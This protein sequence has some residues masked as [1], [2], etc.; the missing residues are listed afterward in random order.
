MIHQTWARPL[1]GTLFSTDGFLPQGYCIA[2][3][4]DLLWTM[5]S[6]DLL[7]GLSYWCI[8]LSLLYFRRQRRKRRELRIAG[9]DGLVVMFCLFIFGCGTIHLLDVLNVWRPAYWAQAGI[10][11]L[12]AAM[13]VGTAVALWR[14][15][16]VAIRFIHERERN[17]REL[18]SGNLRL[19]ESLEL[20]E[21]QREGLER[22][23]R[24]SQLMQSCRDAGELA[25]LVTHTAREWSGAP[26]GALFMAEQPG[27]R[28]E[29]ASG[30][31]DLSTPNPPIDGLACW[32]LRQGRMHPDATSQ[33]TPPCR[34]FA[35][36]DTR[37][38]CFPLVAENQN[39][40]VL[41][42]RGVQSIEDPQLRTL[43]TAFVA[44]AA[45]SLA[46]IQLRERLLAQSIRDPLT[47]MFNRR[48]LEE[49]L[50]LEETRARRNGGSFAVIM[51]DLDHFK[52]LNDRFGHEAGDRAL[53]ALAEIVRCQL[54]GGDVACRY[55]GE[56][57]VLVLPGA[58]VQVA[59][60]RAEAI[61]VE[62]ERTVLEHRG[63]TLDTIT[64]SAGVAAFPDFG[65]SADAVLRSADAA[66]YRAK[67]HG[68]NRCEC[69][70]AEQP[71]MAMA[72]AVPEGD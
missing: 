61:R 4:P 5:A 68:R 20:I 35:A 6:S 50:R 36:G 10:K 12:T 48:F 29:F 44:R 26:S 15:A 13:S 34:Y 16:P 3:S 42:L 45:L 72:V 19:K 7:I 60:Q 67:S 9:F 52:R 71:H 49:S 22:L 63:E 37:H 39:S 32:A 1:A 24:V 55:G 17:G 56:E 57:F 41:Q 38:L 64:A 43:L 25:L 66:L 28:A 59:L 23:N 40:G 31:G 46:N 30:W 27:G 8:P 2:W 65:D 47:G 62:L 70:L 54:R 53:C 14:M 58:A 51:F 18:E 21:Q 69:A 11:A 33:A